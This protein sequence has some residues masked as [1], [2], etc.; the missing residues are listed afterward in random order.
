MNIYQKFGL[1]FIVALSLHLLILGAFGINLVDEA[2][3]IK[4]KPLPEIIQ[5]SILDDNKIQQEANRLKAN[6]ENKRIAQN[7]QQQRLENN[8]KKEQRLLADAKKKRQH[9]QKIAKELVKKRKKK[10]VEEQRKLEE[11]K[12]QRVIEAAR[13]AKIKQ[14]KATE[15]ARLEKIK[16]KKLLEKRRLADLKKVEAK[17]REQ[18]QQAL[19]EKQQHE[20]AEKL[21]Q[22]QRQAQADLDQIARDKQ[23][24]I[25]ITA[26]IQNNVMNRWIKPPTSENGLKC[27]IRVKLLPTGDVM[28]VRVIN[29][30][31]DTIFDRSAE[32]AVRKAS[33][34]P[35]PESRSLFNKKFRTFTFNFNPK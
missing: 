19:I 30:S 16:Q 8:R 31:G 15:T 11:I 14:Q 35:V 10:A 28:D 13:L 26:A 3:L 7:K 24:T 25:N 12:Q 1:S 2:E 32:N 17:K 20:A 21:A 9:E 18:V 29:G 33:P 4:Q 5:A 27:T 22:L 6:E 23:T 34:L